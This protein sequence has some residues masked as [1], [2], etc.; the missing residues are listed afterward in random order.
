MKI[1]ETGDALAMQSSAKSPRRAGT[2]ARHA[3][4]FKKRRVEDLKFDYPKEAFEKVDALSQWNESV[5]RSWFSPWLQWSA[6]PVT[7]LAQKWAHPMRAQRYLFSPQVWPAMA[8]I[9]FAAAWARTVRQPVPDDN[10]WRMREKASSQAIGGAF[11]GWRKQ[12]GAAQERLFA[13]LYGTE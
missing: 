11:E 1:D 7:A 6:N 8:W 5:Y 9:P 2:L 10:P 13:R 4:R 3:V 12:R